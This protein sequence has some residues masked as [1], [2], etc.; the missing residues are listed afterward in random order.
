MRIAPSI[1]SCLAI[2]FLLT[3]QLSSADWIGQAKEITRKGDS[4]V[5]EKIV[6]LMDE[7]AQKGSVV[8]LGKDADERPIF[9]G[10]QA[11]FERLFTQLLNSGTLKKLTCIIHTPAP[12]T[13]LC[14]NGEISEGLVDPKLLSDPDRLLTVKKRPDI[15]RDFLNAGGQ[16]YTV[17]PQAGRN[18]RS[19]EQLRI[20]DSLLQKYPQ[21]LVAVELSCKEIPKTLIGATYLLEFSDRQQFALS[22]M[23]YQANQPTDDAWGIWFGPRGSFAIEER[24]QSVLPF[25]QQNGYRG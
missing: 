10:A 21:Q 13:P 3:A 20:L 15:L 6:S 12:A 11:D 23:S 18:V 22:L 5:K 14:T 2:P 24:L 17:Y 4:A 1:F 9:V 8:R 7:L 16:I 19:Q 25:L